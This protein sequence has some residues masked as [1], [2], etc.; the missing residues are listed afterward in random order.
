MNEIQ[1]ERP[2]W[3]ERAQRV[4]SILHHLTGG[5]RVQLQRSSRSALQIAGVEHKVVC[6]ARIQRTRHKVRLQRIGQVLDEH[7]LHVFLVERL[8]TGA[9]HGWAR[10]RWGWVANCW[11][12]WCAYA[13]VEVGVAVCIAL[14]SSRL[15]F[16]YR[17][18]LFEVDL[19]MKH[20]R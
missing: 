16:V 20:L 13:A 10:Y 2:T 3:N 17:S 14:A 11:K 5:A 6:I 19:K 9:G 15:M 8:A 7:V 18:T 1:S 12:T 4:I